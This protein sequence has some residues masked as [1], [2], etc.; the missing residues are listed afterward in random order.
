M[1]KEEV[2]R[3]AIRLL[4][5]ILLQQLV[6]TNTFNSFLSLSRPYCSLCMC[7]SLFLPIALVLLGQA[8]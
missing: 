3:K 6:F 4:V 1:K 2:H 7:L 5:Y 8:Y